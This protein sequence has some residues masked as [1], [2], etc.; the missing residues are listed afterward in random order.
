MLSSKECTL[1]SSIPIPTA[2]VYIENSR[3]MVVKQVDF[4]LAPIQNGSSDLSQQNK[5]EI[6]RNFLKII[7]LANSFMN[8]NFLSYIKKLFMISFLV[9]Y[10]KK[11]RENS[12]RSFVNKGL[13]RVTLRQ[14][15]K[16][17]R[18]IKLSY[19]MYQRPYHTNLKINF[20][21]EAGCKL[22]VSD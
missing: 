2:S 4:L 8:H 9:S 14:G 20:S 3:I 11:A 15:A 5:I 1:P 19:S 17:S 13:I 7:L 6:L 22:R 10:K 16:I 18:I 12:V 21:S